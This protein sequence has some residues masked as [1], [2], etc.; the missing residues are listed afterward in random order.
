MGR[1]GK[2]MSEEELGYDPLLKVKGVTAQLATA[3]RDAGYYT[4]ESIA[5]EVPHFLVERVGEKAGLTVEKAR[6]IVKNARDMLPI[7]IMTVKELYEEELKRKR[8]PTG[9]RALDEI[10]GG[11]ICTHELTEVTGPAEAGKTELVYTS[12]ILAIKEHSFPVWVIDTEAT[13]SAHRIYEIAEARGLTPEEIT[14][15]MLFDRCLT[16]AELTL[17]IERAHKIIKEKGI[18]YLCI[19]S[20]VS[21]FRRDYPGREF[22]ATRQQRINYCAGMLLK[23]SWAY[24]MA[25]LVTN[26]V[27]ARPEAVYTDKP[28]AVKVPVG[29]HVMWHAANN[30]IY[31]MPSEREKWKWL[32]TLIASSY[33]PRGECTFHIGKAGIEDI[34]EKAEKSP[35]SEK[36]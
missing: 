18:K 19:D 17:T 31:V 14:S 10:L 2:N 9:S 13:L 20:F 36:R 33:L 15:N 32:A 4:V 35:V 22:L 28:E 24:E 30:R 1:G 23:Y 12:A 6:E 8:I 27:M 3:F 26:P 25:V 11:G 34:A 5:V 7:K 29:G 21:P 16:S